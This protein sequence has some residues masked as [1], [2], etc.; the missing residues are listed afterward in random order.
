MQDMIHC[1]GTQDMWT[2]WVWEWHAMYVGMLTH[3][4]W[5]VIHYAKTTPTWLTPRVY[6]PPPP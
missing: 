1:N 4:K 5:N 3:G 6:L 2:G